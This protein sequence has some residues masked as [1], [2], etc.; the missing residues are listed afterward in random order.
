M[1]YSCKHVLYYAAILLHCI[2]SNRFRF[3][4]GLLSIDST[5]QMIEL[6]AS[7]FI[8]IYLF[9]WYETEI[10]VSYVYLEREPGQYRIGEKSPGSEVC[11]FIVCEYAAHKQHVSGL[12]RRFSLYENKSLTLTKL[13]SIDDMM[14]AAS[15]SNHSV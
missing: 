4:L 14:T 7:N 6:I 3:S 2:A 12:N 13:W 1:W 5:H 10:C 9:I 15:D 11:E 8:H